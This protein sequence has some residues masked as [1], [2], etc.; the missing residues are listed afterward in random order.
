MLDK[1]TSGRSE[2]LPTLS[3]AEARVLGR[4]LLGLPADETDLRFRGDLKRKGYLATEGGRTIL[5]E[6]LRPL[7]TALR[8]LIANTPRAG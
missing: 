5:A 8:R 2:G 3:A 7:S 1:G 6:P 4:Y